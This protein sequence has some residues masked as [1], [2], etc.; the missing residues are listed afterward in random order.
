MS[1][2][3]LS[4]KDIKRDWHLIDANGKILGRLST[5][6]AKILAGKN[7]AQ[8]VPYLDNGDYVVVINAASVKVTGKKAKQKKYVHHSGYRGGIRIE[9]FEKLNKRRPEEIVRHA[10][11]GMLPKNKLADKM[12]KKLHIFAGADHDFKK[13][14]E[15]KENG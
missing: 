7:K 1:T 5:E 2:N 14:L 12:I 15:S 13:Q 11:L 4:I 10:V 6:I 8:F 3:I 9:T